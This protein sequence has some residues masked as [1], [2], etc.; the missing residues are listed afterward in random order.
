MSTKALASLLGGMAL[1]FGAATAS[2]QQE[3][4]VRG[5]GVRPYTI[6]VQPISNT[7]SAVPGPG[8]GFEAFATER[9]SVFVN[10]TYADVDMDNTTINSIRARSGDDDA[11]P[12]VGY[13][14]NAALG[15]RWY[16][17]PQRSSWYGGA[18]VG[19]SEMDSKWEVGDEV[20]K[21]TVVSVVPGVSAGYRWLWDNNVLLRVGAGVA[22]NNV[23]TKDFTDEN[24]T[25]EAR[26]AEDTVRDLATQ[27][28]IANMDF[29][30]GYAF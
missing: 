23:Q 20:V 26:D 24:D 14:Y 7:L 13:G 25:A 12:T 18:G 9:V 4:N 2:A 11:I 16:S 28:V 5:Q 8:L 19:Y 30:I 3:M 6:E 22:S 10:G 17:A 1:V 29:G 27:P 15:A 21:A